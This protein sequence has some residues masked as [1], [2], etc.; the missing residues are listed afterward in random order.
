MRIINPLIAA[1]IALLIASPA[2]ATQYLNVAQAQ[3]IMFP[4][5]DKFV[6]SNVNLTAEQKKQIKSM[7]G[8]VQRWDNQE[9]WRAEKGGKLIGFVIIDAVIGK[10]EYITYAAGLLTDGRVRGLE[11]MTYN[12]TRGDQV[13]APQWRANFGGKTLHDAFK[14]DKDIPNISGATLSCLN[15]TNGIKRLLALQAV[16]L[17]RG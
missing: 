13:R 10:H 5:A 14:L 11:I 4:D 15:L 3:K 12:E 7:S 6:Q 9:V 17:P 16:A 2:M 8:V 1:P